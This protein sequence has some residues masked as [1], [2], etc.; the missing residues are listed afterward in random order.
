MELIAFLSFFGLIS[1][2]ML[3]WA[4]RELWEQNHRKD[5]INNN[6][7]KELD[8]ANLP[9]GYMKTDYNVRIYYRDGKWG[10]LESPCT[11]PP[12]VYITVRRPSR[13]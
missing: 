9:F 12:H 4:M 3:I 6:I 7:M 11:W 10:E 5:N 2:G 1:L 13:G 8:W